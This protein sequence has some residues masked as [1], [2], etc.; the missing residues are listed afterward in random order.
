MSHTNMYRDF[1]LLLH[2]NILQDEDVIQ[3]QKHIYTI[4]HHHGRA[5]PW[6]ETTNPY[7]IVVSEIMLQQTQVN[8]VI[9]FYERF[10]T[11]LPTFEALANAT[12]RDVLTLWSGLGY[13]R[14]GLALH[15]IAKLVMQNYEGSLPVDP[16]ELQKLP[17]IG[18]NTAGSIAA[19]AFNYPSIFIETNIRT[20]FLYCFFREKV[21]VTDKELM[22]LIEQTL[23]KNNPRHWYYALMDYGTIL[24]KNV[25]N[26]NRKS[27]H[28]T[29]Q[30][31]FVG[32][33]RRVRGA[34]IRQLTQI[35]QIDSNQLSLSLTTG[36]KPIA[37]SQEQFDRVVQQLCNEHII[38]CRNNT[39]EINSTIFTTEHSVQ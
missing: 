8:R 11:A 13:N 27:K 29:V 22:P 34:I 38:I 2:D 19:F 31:K 24:K 26:P 35:H 10:I 12:P 17:G 7:H 33:D 23:D 28:Y 32:S 16:S 4:Y 18:P 30:S 9:P 39:L 3:F 14:R 25:I 37:T 1:S 6:R 36:K 20:V 5:F 21:D 15:A